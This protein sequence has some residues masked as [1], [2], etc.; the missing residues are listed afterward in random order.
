MLRCWLVLWQPPPDPAARPV[1]LTVLS[2][3]SS[4]HSA[5]PNAAAWLRTSPLRQIVI[6]NSPPLVSSSRRR[7]MPLQYE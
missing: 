4:V 5:A 3:P 7:R 1:V 2:M 6:R